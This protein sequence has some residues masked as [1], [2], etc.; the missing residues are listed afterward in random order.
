METPSLEFQLEGKAIIKAVFAFWLRFVSLEACDVCHSYL[1]IKQRKIIKQLLG[2]RRLFFAI[3]PLSDGFLV[4]IALF[5][6][7]IAP[8]A[9]EPSTDKLLLCAFAIL[10]SFP[11]SILK[12]SSFVISEDWQDGLAWRTREIRNNDGFPLVSTR[13]RSSKWKILLAYIIIWIRLSLFAL[14][15]LPSFF[16]SCLC[17]MIE[18]E[19]LGEKVEEIVSHD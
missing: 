16:C 1:Q 10:A 19:I 14:N 18:M 6:Y 11:F 5:R 2:R 12:V 8:Y 13:W 9:L 4:S 7:F 3:A 17:V 15:A